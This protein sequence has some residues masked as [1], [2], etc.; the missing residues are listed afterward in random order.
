MCQEKKLPLGVSVSPCHAQMEWWIFD[1]LT[2]CCHRPW[3][4][5][6]ASRVWGV[7]LCPD[8][9]P[10]HHRLCA[11][12]CPS[13]EC[14]HWILNPRTSVA[15]RDP[16]RSSPTSLS[17][18]VCSLLKMP[19]FFPFD[20]LKNYCFIFCLYRCK[21][22]CLLAPNSVKVWFKSPF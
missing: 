7:P 6:L 8:G 9:F 16:Q 1:T 12:F 15:G 3:V 22:L 11:H 21:N 14:F 5:L 19:H 18:A 10:S 4:L 2:A 13:E 20:M 17:G